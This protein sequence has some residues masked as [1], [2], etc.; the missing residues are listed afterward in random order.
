MDKNLSLFGSDFL[1]TNVAV[2]RYYN[3]E[4]PVYHKEKIGFFNRKGVEVCKGSP[5]K[6]IIITICSRI[7][8]V[9]VFH[10]SKLIGAQ[11]T[12]KERIP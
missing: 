9:F 3:C 8:E 7:P 5:S 6:Q 12:P 4:H 11:I 2:Q 10:V 1:K